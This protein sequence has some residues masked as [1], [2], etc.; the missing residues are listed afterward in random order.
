MGI[1]IEEVK[2]WNTPLVGAYLLW[3]FTKGYINNHDTKEAPIAI[4][5]FIASAI[6]T[7][8]KLI[9]SISRRRDGLPSYIRSFEEKKESDLLLNIHEEVKNKKEY[10]QRS[11]D[12]A[13]SCGLLVW[14][15]ENGKLYPKELIKKSSPGKAIKPDLVKQGEKAE[16]LGSWFSKQDIHS[17]TT[18]LKVVL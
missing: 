1:L 2:T 8:P 11:I 7:N 9:E 16:I 5:H 18:Y 13:T 17:I 4:L 10:T 15:I 12:I 6:L 14:D 3:R